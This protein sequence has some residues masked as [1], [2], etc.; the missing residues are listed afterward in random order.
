MET[1][2][3]TDAFVQ[4]ERAYLKQGTIFEYG[5]HRRGVGKPVTKKTKTRF[6]K[7][8]GMGFKTPKLAIEGKYIDHKC[9]WTGDVS[10]RGRILK[11]RVIS[12]K[13]NKTIVVRRDNLH[14][15]KKYQRYEKRHS[16]TP[17][18]V[19]PA[20]LVKEGDTVT[21]GECRPL[22]KTVRFNVLEVVP[23]TTGFTQRKK[24]FRVF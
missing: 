17:A 18:H 2:E 14:Y 4:N 5:K 11:G 13:M 20:F 12:T 23:V 8:V 16:N 6:V 1:R 22:S 15:V 9:P 19:S 21:I 3:P 24:Q 10:I 7:R